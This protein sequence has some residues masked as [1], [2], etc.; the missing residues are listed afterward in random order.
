[1]APGNT[2]E[3]HSVI[4]YKAMKNEKI[5]VY[6]QGE[7]I[8]ENGCMLKT[9]VWYLEIFEKGK[10]GEVFNLGSGEEKEK[11]CKKYSSDNQ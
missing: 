7:N 9:A 1:M 3:V 6:E 4:I 8:L 5:P 2:W 11:N 10:I